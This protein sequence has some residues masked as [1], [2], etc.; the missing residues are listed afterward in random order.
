MFTARVLGGYEAK[1]KGYRE[2]RAHSKLCYQENFKA[3]RQQKVEGR[4]S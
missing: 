4:D 3:R 1:Q 2:R